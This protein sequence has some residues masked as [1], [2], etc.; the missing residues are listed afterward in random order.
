MRKDS[1]VLNQGGVPLKPTNGLAVER[2]AYFMW[3]YAI[4]VC[5]FAYC[6][7]CLCILFSVL[8]LLVQLYLECDLKNRTLLFS[9]IYHA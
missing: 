2:A 7:T 5:A 1:L 8:L 6:C 3:F 9:S 4:L